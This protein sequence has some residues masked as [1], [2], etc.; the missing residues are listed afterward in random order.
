[1]RVLIDTNVVID[2]IER[3]EPFLADSYAVLRLIAEDEL[4]GFLPAG[5]VADVYYII[6]KSKDA[7]TA[8]GAILAL[9]E[10]VALCDTTAGDISSALLLGFS[11]FED[12]ILAA[13]A[14]REKADFIITR[15]ERDFAKSPVS[16]ISP[17]DF[18]ARVALK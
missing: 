6:K 10:L 1:M 2:V 14:K 7:G 11:D 18:L 3:R 8:Q 17:K 12:A 15:N 16:A 5:S 13:T 9:L 4:T